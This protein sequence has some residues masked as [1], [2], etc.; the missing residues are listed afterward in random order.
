VSLSA[1]CGSPHDHPD[2]GDMSLYV[3][4]ES[5]VPHAVALARRYCLRQGA[6]AL[7]AAQ[8]ATVASELANNLWMHTTEGGELLLRMLALDRPGVE[9]W[10]LDVGPGIPDIGA[11]MREGFST[12]G[13]LGFGLPGAQRLMDEFELR[14]RPGQGTQVRTLKWLKAS[15]LAGHRSRGE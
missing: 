4:R 8:V 11:A 15:S 14:S 13:G 10:S 9:L 3:R 2:P 12:G 1:E 6:S 5:D 7:Q